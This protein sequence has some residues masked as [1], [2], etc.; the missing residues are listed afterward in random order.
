ML[1]DNIYEIAG[2]FKSLCCIEMP[3]SAS[4]MPTQSMRMGI[5]FITRYLCHLNLWFERVHQCIELRN[6][7]LLFGITHRYWRIR[8]YFYH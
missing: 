3:N 2:S 7:Q 8:M 6:A 1:Q 4:T 5:V